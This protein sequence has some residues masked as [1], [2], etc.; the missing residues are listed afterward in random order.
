M[1]QNRSPGRSHRILRLA[2]AVLAVVVTAAAHTEPL[3]ADIVIGLAA[4]LGGRFAEIGLAMREGAQAAA[5]ETND[6]GGIAGDRLQLE[7][8]DDGCAS[9]TGL[10][11]AQKLVES[12]ARIV[13]G[14]WCGSAAV[15]AAPVYAAAQIV[16]I[17][18]TRHD[19]VTD[20][21]AGPGIFR[22]AGR[23]DQQGQE[24]ARF[25]ANAHKGAPIALVHDRTAYARALADGFLSA[26]RA[27]DVR[28]VVSEGI[29]AGNKDYSALT[30]RIAEVG[31]RIVYFAGFPSEAAI[32]LAELRAAGSPALLMGPDSLA[33]AEFAELAGPRADGAVVTVSVATDAA[34]AARTAAKAAVEIAAEGLRHA[35]RDGA[36]MTKHLAVGTFRTALG[37]VAF[38]AK[39]DASIAGFAIHT[40]RGG[41][42]APAD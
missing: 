21:R 42:L 36:A 41:R 6:R 22:L 11:A 26:M 13:I 35:P 40:W 8:V 29:V 12:G 3:K 27:Q 33:V 19:A 4:P 31:A 2:G 23:D 16:L 24:A 1:T 25:V 37:P 9:G 32:M 38:D 15:A 17:T 10:A 14:H 5:T 18:L 39:G 20:R 28:P 7:S 34:A 30:R